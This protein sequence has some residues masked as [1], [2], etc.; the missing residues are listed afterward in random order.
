MNFKSVF[1]RETK[2]IVIAVACMGIVLI[3]GSYAL[4]YKM[5]QN[6]SSQVV[7]AG[8]LVIEYSNGNAVDLINLGLDDDSCLQPVSDAKGASNSGCQFTFTVKNK[9]SLPMTYD[10][11]IGNNSTLLPSGGTFLSHEYIRHTLVKTVGSAS[12]T[13]VN[14]SKKLSEYTETDQNGNRIIEKGAVIA[15][16]GAANG[17]DTVQYTLNIW[18]DENAPTD[19]IGQYVLLNYGVSGGIEGA[20]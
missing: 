13:V 6:S 2:I 5:S 9:G 8:S 3:G 12:N 11:T 10:L 7:E 14:N 15:A 1:K 4:F 17:A 19:I 18:I 16:K 20:E